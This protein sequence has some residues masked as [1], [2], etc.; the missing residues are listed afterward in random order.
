MP[1]VDTNLKKTKLFCM[2]NFIKA[3]YKVIWAVL[4]L[5]ELGNYGIK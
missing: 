3:Y 4:F 1:A 5:N 2:H